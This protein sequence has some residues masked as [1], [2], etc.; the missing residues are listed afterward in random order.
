MQNRGVTVY[1]KKEKKKDSCS[2]QTAFAPVLVEFD[3][4]VAQTRMKSYA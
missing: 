2:Y 1:R 4:I 3:E